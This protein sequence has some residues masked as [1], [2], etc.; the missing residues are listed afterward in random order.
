MNISIEDM[1]LELRRKHGVE[2]NLFD[3][4]LLSCQAGPCKRRLT[5]LGCLKIHPSAKEIGLMKF[6]KKHWR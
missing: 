6:F 2:P 4:I 3:L 1:I 5:A